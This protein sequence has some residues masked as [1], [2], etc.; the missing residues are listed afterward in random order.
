MRK[1]QIAQENKVPFN[2]PKTS[3]SNLSKNPAPMKCVALWRNKPN[4]FTRRTIRRNKM[5]KL[6]AFAICGFWM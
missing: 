4:K 1:K 2:A 5:I 3:P 6:T